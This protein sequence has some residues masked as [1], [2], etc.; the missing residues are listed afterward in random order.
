MR[1]SGTISIVL[2]LLNLSASFVSL[3]PDTGNG[4]IVV[5]FIAQSCESHE[6]D[7]TDESQSCTPEDCKHRLCS[8]Q[9]LFDEYLPNSSIQLEAVLPPAVFICD[10]LFS[11]DTRFDSAIR[12]FFNPPILITQNSPVLRI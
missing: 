3:C 9:P 4:G 1:F 6:C 8:D 11:H 2:I 12:R 7:H 10:E 5:H